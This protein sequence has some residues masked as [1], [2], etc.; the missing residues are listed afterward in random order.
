MNL[1]TL[2]PLR[3]KLKVIHN[4]DS[5]VVIKAFTYPIAGYW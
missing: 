4:D 3:S 2:C 5:L 1:I